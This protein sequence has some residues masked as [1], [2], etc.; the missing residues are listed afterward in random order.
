MYK[1]AELFKP[2]SP[3]E[4]LNFQEII[5]TEKYPCVLEET[6]TEIIA[7]AYTDEEIVQK[8]QK[9][10]NKDFFLTSSGYIRRKVHM[11]TGETKDFLSDLLPTISMGVQMGQ[12][13]K[14]IAYSMPDFTQEVIDWEQYQTIITA[15][16]QFIQE[17]FVQLSN[18]FKPL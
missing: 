7:Y 11:A 18:D 5:N 10:F 12:Q 14:I 8:Q 2:Y 4:A 13:V 1:K 9:E 6:E 15:D 3:Q 16:A 17:C